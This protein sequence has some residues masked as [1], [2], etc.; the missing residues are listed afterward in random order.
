MDEQKSKPIPLELT[1]TAQL[2]LDTEKKME[3]LQAQINE[4]DK[5]GVPKPT[6]TPSGAPP[7]GPH[8]GRE[9][10]VADKETLK[11]KALEIVDAIEKNSNGQTKQA[12][13]NL[14]DEWVMDMEP[15]KQG[16]DPKL[17]RQM[18][19][20]S[21]LNSPVWRSVTGEKPA[22]DFKKN[23]YEMTGQTHEIIVQEPSGF[24][25]TVFETT[26][27]GGSLLDRARGL[28]EEY[29]Y[30]D[31]NSGKDKTRETIEITGPSES[32]I[33]PEEP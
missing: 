20:L 4:M 15:P 6:F 1:T 31:D 8:T 21:R 7:S 32:E 24:Q 11:S 12:V 25:Q 10:L 19:D 13:K 18:R 16:E 17:R 30:L 23:A 3:K 2:L 14:K 5:K 22:T 28:Q 26:N 29:S 27:K 9:K 33:E